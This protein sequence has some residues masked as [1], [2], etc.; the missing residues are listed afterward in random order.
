MHQVCVCVCVN[1]F[2][3]IGKNI[4]AVTHYFIKV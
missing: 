3:N 2:V 4:C 1:I